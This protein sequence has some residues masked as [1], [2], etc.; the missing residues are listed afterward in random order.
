PS[1]FIAL[2]EYDTLQKPKTRQDTLNIWAHLGSH[3]C[4]CKPAGINEV[5]NSI[6]SIVYPNPMTGS[7]LT[8]QSSETIYGYTIY[9]IEGKLITDKKV[10][11]PQNTFEVKMENMMNGIYFVKLQHANGKYS[12]TR[13][14]KE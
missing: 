1:A 11:F 4:N 2:N 7:I 12:A 13:F 6:K 5:N 14:S 9:S 3:T 8:I 10:A